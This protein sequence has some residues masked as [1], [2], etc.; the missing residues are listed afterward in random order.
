M[1]HECVRQRIT[2]ERVERF[3][4]PGLRAELGK[5][6]VSIDERDGRDV[7]ALLD[8]ARRALGSFVGDVH[9]QIDREVGRALPRIADGVGVVHRD[10]QPCRQRERRGDDEN[11]ENARERLAREARDGAEQIG[12]MQAEVVLERVARAKASAAESPAS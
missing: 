11:R 9:L 3:A 4:E 8:A 7:V 10:P 12:A 5:C 1:D 2:V 6:G